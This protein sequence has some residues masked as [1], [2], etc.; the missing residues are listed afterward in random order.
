MDKEVASLIKWVKDS[1]PTVLDMWSVT[2]LINEIQRLDEF[3]LCCPYCTSGRI[4]TEMYQKYANNDQIINPKK[5]F[6]KK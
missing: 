2:K 1:D 5:G 3:E 6:W 4:S